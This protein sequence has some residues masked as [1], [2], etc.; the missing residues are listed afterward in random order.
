MNIDFSLLKG[1]GKIDF[2]F[3]R[4]GK[5]DGNLK[6]IV[7]GHQDHPLSD[8]GREQASLT[9]S[10]LRDKN[11]R[12]AFSTP[13]LRGRDTARV[14]CEA[15][16][17]PEAVPLRSLIE[18]DTGIF[19]GLTLEEARLK[20]PEVYARFLQESWEAVDAAEKAAAL[21]SRAASAWES[22]ITAAAEAAAAAPASEAGPPA[23]PFSVLAVAHAGILQWL[24]KA[25]L[26]SE[27]WFPL[28]PMGD[29]GIYHFSAEEAVTRWERLNYQVPG[30]TGKR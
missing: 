5:S 23:R 10:W 11:I 12:L 27:S 24:V 15:A 8:L 13:L 25:T 26:G 3:L 6:G 22:L 2:Y 1:R 17:A 29:C 4:H 7:Q 20:H 19:T 14:I 21:L 28:L 9:G 18:L 16:G 30:V